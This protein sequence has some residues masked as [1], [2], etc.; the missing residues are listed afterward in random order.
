MKPFIGGRRTII[1]NIVRGRYQPISDS[2]LKLK[3]KYGDIIPNLLEVDPNSRLNATEVI[4]ILEAS[5]KDRHLPDTPVV[6]QEVKPAISE[7]VLSKIKVEPGTYNIQQGPSFQSFGA[8]WDH[9]ALAEDNNIERLN[10]RLRSSEIENGWQ[11]GQSGRL[12]GAIV[13]E[14]KLMSRLD[15][16]EN[17]WQIGQSGQMD[18]GQMGNN[19][20]EQRNSVSHSYKRAYE[21]DQSPSKKSRTESNPEIICNKSLQDAD[22]SCNTSDEG[23]L[24]SAVRKVVSYQMTPKQALSH[25]NLTPKVLFESLLGTDE[26]RKSILTK[27]DL[28]DEVEEVVI[29][30][31]RNNKER[32]S[33]RAVIN[34]VRELKGGASEE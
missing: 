34:L 32:L 8:A 10:S 17:G 15:D 21:D 20:Q 22:R 6:I 14:Q 3:F 28:S 23:P 24:D 33:Y 25:Y 27:V 26:D 30:F 31:C 16:I 13:R 18:G 19:L 4:E 11:I 7:D 5:D 12:D 1:D 2:T 29:T 9:G